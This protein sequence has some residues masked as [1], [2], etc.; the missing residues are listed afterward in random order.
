VAGETVNNRRDPDEPID[1]K[2]NLLMAQLG[3]M[4][5]DVDPPPKLAIEL[6]RRSFMLRDVDAELARLVEDSEA[7]GSPVAVRGAD[8]TYNP[9]QLTFEGQGLIIALEVDIAGN[10]RRLSGQVIPIGPA[11][12]ELR[13]PVGRKPRAAPVD[14]LGRF[15]FDDVRAGPTS[16]TCRRAGFPPVTTAWTLL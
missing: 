10:R 3:E 1:P 16:V 5:R 6:A 9:R 2:D 14:G 7:V 11:E 8:A 4:F 13:Q 12:M 15:M